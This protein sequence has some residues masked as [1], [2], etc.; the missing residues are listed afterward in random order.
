MNSKK[1]KSFSQEDFDK[2]NQKV[3]ELNNIDKTDSA[4]FYNLKTETI[5]LILKLE[6]YYFDKMSSRYSKTYL[7]E[8]VFAT[9]Y[10]DCIVE[11]INKYKP[12]KNSK[13]TTYFAQILN[14]RVLDIL[15][16]YKKDISLDSA[17]A[18]EDGDGDSNL[19]DL[20]ES[21]CSYESTESADALQTVDAYLIRYIMYIVE[22][23]DSLNR[24]KKCALV[25]YYKLF[26]TTRL[27]DL[28][29]KEPSNNSEICQSLKYHENETIN[30]A[31][32]GLIDFT[33]VE[34]TN[35][36]D[37]MFFN[38]LKRYNQ[39]PYIDEKSR[40]DKVLDVP[41]RNKV[42]LAYLEANY[43]KKV[44]EAIVSK[45]KKKFDSEICSLKNIW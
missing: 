18:N 12:N 4:V 30:C 5:G 23:L 25:S 29:K 33:Y 19:Y 35:T 17:F 45:M 11:C 38:S 9:T 37:E 2:I 8:D 10:L 28:V 6:E 41:Y 34:I 24:N 44:S 21:K 16:K 39:L 26:Y 36:I 14:Y 31:E 7:L 20:I 1:G 32:K 27:V 3:F 15:E 43:D 13:F 42:L 22:L 40:T